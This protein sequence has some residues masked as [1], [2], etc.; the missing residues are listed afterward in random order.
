MNR[1]E[2][3]ERHGE[4]TKFVFKG[5]YYDAGHSSKTKCALC[6][7]DIHLVYVLKNDR[8]RSTPISSCCFTY[9]KQWNPTVHTQLCAAAVLL[10]A[11][12]EAEARDKK[13]FAPMMEVRERREV[14][15]TM[16][17]KALDVIR[18]YKIKTGKEW[19]PEEL[20]DLKVVAEQTPSDF[21]RVTSAIRW[22]QRQTALLETK[23]Q[24]ATTK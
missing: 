15:R 6:G 3:V 20:F 4:P 12:I 22:F 13:V 16:K 21:K 8:D 1:S 10:G 7:Q 18:E 14:W 19:L 24:C 23:L 17:R 11:T 2:F 9:F 5:Q